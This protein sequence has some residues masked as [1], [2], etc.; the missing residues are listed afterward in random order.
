MAVDI[1]AVRKYH[2]YKLSAPAPDPSRFLPREHDPNDYS[3]S[4]EP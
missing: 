2:G 1:E 3:L 4:H